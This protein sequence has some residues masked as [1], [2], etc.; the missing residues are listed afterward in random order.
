M[1]AISVRSYGMFPGLPQ[2]F[3]PGHRF[4]LVVEEGTT[5]AQL[6]EQVFGIPRGYVAVVAVN[7]QVENEDCALQERDRVDLFPQIAGG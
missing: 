6:V 4:E 7:D 1:I 5:V 3:R 2:E